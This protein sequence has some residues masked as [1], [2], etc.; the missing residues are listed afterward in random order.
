[1]SR[2]CLSSMPTHATN[3]SGVTSIRINL[4]DP[5]IR[6]AT[7]AAVS[8]EPRRITPHIA[9]IYRHRLGGTAPPTLSRRETIRDPHGSPFY[10][11]GTEPFG[12]T[13]R[14]A[15]WGLCLLDF[16]LEVQYSTGKQHHAVDTLS[17]RKPSDPEVSS[18]TDPV[19][20][21]IPC[22]RSRS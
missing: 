2:T 20:T 21:E 4:T 5:S 3:R 8:R 13:R 16:D 12:L 11:M 6:S 9:G 18:P 15:L 17:R 22:F 7:G 14:L 19:D 1:V 10:P